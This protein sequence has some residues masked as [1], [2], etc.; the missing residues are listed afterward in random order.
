MTPSTATWPATASPRGWSGRKCVSRWGGA[1]DGYGVFDD[2]VL[3][4]RHADKIE[5]VRRQYR[6]NEHRVIKGIGVGTW[7]YVNPQTAQV[8]IMDYRSYD[9]E[10]DGKSQRAHV[11][12]RLSSVVY[13][14]RL[15]FRAVL[16]DTWYATKDFMLYIEEGQKL[17]Y[18]P[19]K[20]N[21][22]VDDSGGTRPYRRV[23]TLEWSEAEA[24]HGKT[25]T[26][27]DFPKEHKGK[28]FR[29]VLS[30][31]RTD[32]VVTNDHAQDSTAATQEVCGWRWKIEQFHRESKQVTG[33]EGGQCR[34]ARLVRNPI[35]CA[36][37]VWVRLNQ[38]AHDTQQTIYQVQHGLL[39]D[40]LRQ[41]LRSP[42]VKMS[43]A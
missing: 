12:D 35:G 29:V 30:T 18:C 11:H 24:L 1:E 10:G 28:L 5:L 21:R 7:V 38:V 33:L 6:G 40:Y 15:P 31:K 25:I 22:Q 16:M 39:S 17:Y 37:L 36:L 19:L 32:Y 41:H 43:L 20:D 3:D 9:P 23:D 8:W 4:K 42:A 27:K 34:K 13:Q 2:T 14:K 26:I